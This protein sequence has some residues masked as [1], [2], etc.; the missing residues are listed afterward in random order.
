MGIIFLDE[1]D[2]IAKRKGHGTSLTRDVGG[3]GVQQALLKMLEG[4]IVNVPI[5]NPA[6]K[7]SLGDQV[8]LDTSN[9]L[10]IL[11]GAFNGLESFVEERNTAKSIG[12]GG[13][14]AEKATNTTE[15]PINKKTL[16]EKLAMLE[17]IDLISFGLIPEFVG[18]IPILAVLK[19]LDANSLIE[20][21]VKP[22]NSLVKQFTHLFSLNNTILEFTDSGLKEIANLAIARRTGARGLRSIVE[23]ILLPAMYEIPNGK[24]KKVIVNEEVVKNN[25]PPIMIY[26]EN[27]NEAE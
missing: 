5:K 26:H 21:I 6:A 10:F 23:R 4:S 17:T 9:I 18:R 27:V 12:F 24:I 11:S 8:T 19:E 22:Q 14:K 25:L 15:K 20:T 13:L 7:F 16:D 3:E 2:K 1:V